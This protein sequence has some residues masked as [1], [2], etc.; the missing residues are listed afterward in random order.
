MT[1]SLSLPLD[2][3]PKAR[4]RLGKFG[5]YTP[6]RTKQFETDLKTLVKIK[7]KGEPLSGPL[8]MALTFSF[9]EPKKPKNKIHVTRP[10]LDNLQK[11]VFDG[12]NGILWVDDCQIFSC[13]A[14]KK[15]GKEPKIEISVWA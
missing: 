3:V 11:A 4:P 7:Y 12:L 1:I 2:P 10:D 5:T 8:H 14:I 13:H 9:R 15:Y 6:R